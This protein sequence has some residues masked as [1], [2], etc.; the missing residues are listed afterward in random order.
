MK[1]YLIS[2]VTTA[3]VIA[4]SE[5]IVPQGKLK[6]IV[7]TVLSIVLL[8]AMLTPFLN[9]QKDE[10]QSVFNP[11]NGQSESLESQDFDGYFDDRLKEYYQKIFLQKLKTND[12][13]CEKVIV[14][15]SNTSIKK[16][17]IFLSN[18]VIPEDNE[19]INN[20]VIANFVAEILGVNAEKVEIYA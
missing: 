5:L 6:T 8:I 17:K 7:S 13:I 14:E 12:L 9:I 16:I 1:S 10:T 11:D 4:L 3:V 2:V 20:I 15:I 18:L 19:H